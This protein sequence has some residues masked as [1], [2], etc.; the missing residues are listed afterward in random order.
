MDVEAADENKMICL[1]QYY[2]LPKSVAK[3]KCD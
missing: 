3:T 1:Y 2:D